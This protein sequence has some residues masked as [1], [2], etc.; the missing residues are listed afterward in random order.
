MISIGHNLGIKVIAE[1]VEQ[2]EQ[3]SFL[4]TAGCDEMQGYYYS[5]PLPPL[6][7][8]QFLKSGGPLNLPANI[9]DGLERYLLIIDDEP[10]VLSALRRALRL[11]NY[12][13]LTANSSSEAL[14][15]MATNPVDVVLTDLRLADTSGVEF[16]RRIKIIYPD[17]IRMVL[18]GTTEVSSILKAVNE[19]VI[20][21]FIT[22]PWEPEDLRNQLREAFQQRELHRE[23]KH[24]RN[25][26]GLS[27]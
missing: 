26:F 10:G 4:R 14:S 20:Y 9:I 16:L 23:N 22:K 24:L 8:M 18:S 7:C 13:L 3:M 25:K 11:E 5:P 17:A 2:L 15:L 19:G 27:G 1:G 21:R 6:A 12:K